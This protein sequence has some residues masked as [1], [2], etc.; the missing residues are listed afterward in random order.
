MIKYV[1]IFLL[2]VCILYI[3]YSYCIEPFDIGLDW[4]SNNDMKEYISGF[5]GLPKFKQFVIAR[6]LPPKVLIFLQD[7]ATEIIVP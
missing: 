5:S 7:S 2:F 3:L 1:I 4:F 6:G